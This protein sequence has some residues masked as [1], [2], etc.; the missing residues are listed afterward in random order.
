MIIG[1]GR[2]RE[3]PQPTLFTT[4]TGVHNFRL[5]TPEGTPKGVKWPS[6]TS[7]SHGTTTKKKAREKAVHAQ[8]LL[9]V[10]ATSGQGLFRS[11]D[12]RH[13]R[14]KGPTR[15]NMAQLP[16]V[17]AQNI[18]SDRAPDWRHFRSRDWRHCRSRHF[19]LHPLTAPPQM[20]T[21]LYPYTTR[22]IP[23]SNDIWYRCVAHGFITFYFFA[24][25]LLVY[26]TFIF[27]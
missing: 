22:V 5:R 14:S 19:R 18:L 3:H 6:V 16:V 20:L 25:L 4:T 10:R 8:N 2:H 21:E 27:W 12:W 11:R 23:L 15:A 7:G 24:F 1:C 13:F 17:H 9:P 26:N